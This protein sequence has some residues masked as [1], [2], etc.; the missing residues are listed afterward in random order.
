MESESA[1]SHTVK[2][3]PATYRIEQRRKVHFVDTKIL[4]LGRQLVMQRPVGFVLID[5]HFAEADW[6]GKLEP[7]AVGKGYIR[8]DKIMQP[9]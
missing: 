7:R 9:G 4:A 1:K 3:Q 2:C 8:G 6:R 5:A